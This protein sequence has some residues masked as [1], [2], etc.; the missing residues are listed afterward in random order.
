VL[1]ANDPNV[2]LYEYV[3]NA[4]GWVT[5]VYLG[6][7]ADANHLRKFEYTVDGDDGDYV[8]DIYDYTDASNYRVSREYRES[9]GLM[10][11][12]ITY[13]L[14]GEDPADP[15]GDTYTENIF[16][17]FDSNGTMTE[18]VVIPATGDT[19]SPD[20]DSG[21]RRVYVYDE[22]HGRLLTETWYDTND[23][24]FTVVSYAYES[25]PDGKHIRIDYSDDARGARI[26]YTYDGNSVDPNFKEM[27][28][29]DTGPSGP[30]QQLNYEYEYDYRNRV[31]LE[32][33]LDYSATT[34]VQ[35]K[36][37][38][39]DWGNL[40]KQYADWQDSNETTTYIYNGFN[41][42]TRTLS[43]SDVA[44]GRTY[45]DNGLLKSEF[46]IASP[47]D[48]NVAEPS[49]LSQTKYTYDNNG[50][51]TKVEKAVDDEAS[52]T[53][54][55]PDSWI[56]TEYE[57][58]TWGKRVKVTEDTGG[59]ALETLYT[60]NNQGQVT[61]VTEPTGKWTQTSYDGRGLVARVTVGYGSTTFAIT[62]YYYNENGNIEEEVAPDLTKTTYEYDD[63]DRVIKITKGS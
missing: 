51:L 50:R 25:T 35:T 20:P 13:D 33:R 8:V 44:T 4:N 23:V 39:D 60:Y 6:A 47:S 61:K 29:V 54:G 40:I 37:K 57:Y 43:A 5:D 36:Y 3:Y 16:Y 24:N 34:L 17:T 14:A 18:K 15:V 45:Y 46:V 28:E 55:S 52:F 58:D 26:D 22:D 59:F 49:L 53:F 31:T 63:Y 38:Y 2:V 42:P 41:E 30:N 62:D 10:S 11:Q 56:T 48:V 1:D 7:V 9:S 32:K 27:P 19:A 12:R 21:L